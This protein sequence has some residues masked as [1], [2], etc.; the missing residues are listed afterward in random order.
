MKFEFDKQSHDELF[1]KATQQ[2]NND[3]P[4]VFLWSLN[5][6]MVSRPNISMSTSNLRPH[7]WAPAFVKE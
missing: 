5:E 4:C 7:Y 6:I 2:I 1:I 3:M